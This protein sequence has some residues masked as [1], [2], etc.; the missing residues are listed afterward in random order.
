LQNKGLQ[1]QTAETGEQALTLLKHRDFQPQLIITDLWLPG[2]ETEL[3]WLKKL[4][5][6]I[7][8]EL[9]VIVISGDTSP[10]LHNAVEALHCISITKPI[11][12]NHLLRMID[13]FSESPAT[14]NTQ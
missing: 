9:P 12:A 4:R 8:P 13:Q 10:G 3:A 14:R 11:R 1:V 7:G 2:T 6:H 5:N